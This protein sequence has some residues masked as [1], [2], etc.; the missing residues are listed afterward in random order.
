MV[1]Y[2]TNTQHE[3]T[4]RDFSCGESGRVRVYFDRA[5]HKK[6]SFGG[7]WY[8]FVT[9]GWLPFPYGLQGATGPWPRT[10][11]FKMLDPSSDIRCYD[12]WF[13]ISE[14]R[15]CIRLSLAHRSSTTVLSLVEDASSNDSQC[16]MVFRSNRVEHSADQKRTR[17]NGG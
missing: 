12:V 11:T 7:R 16:F 13:A 4:T 3:E 6:S 5:V 2:R 1:Y 17:R 8:S 10:C 14:R 15:I 9:V